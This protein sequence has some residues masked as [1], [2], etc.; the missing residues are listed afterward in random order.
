ML[1]LR[2]RSPRVHHQGRHLRSLTFGKAVYFLSYGLSDSLP[3][4]D[5]RVASVASLAQSPAGALYGSPE[6]QPRQGR[7]PGE[8]MKM[9]ANPG[10]GG[11]MRGINIHDVF[12]SARRAKIKNLR[13]KAP[14]YA[15]PPSGGVLICFY[16]EPGVSSRSRL[17]ARSTIC[18]PRQARVLIFGGPSARGTY[19]FRFS[20]CPSCKVRGAALRQIE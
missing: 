18:H 5:Y 14:L 12:V 15:T 7:N 4:E 6:V 19:N 17:H 20:R 3:I 10:R 11:I 9:Y 13:H 8:K 16:S 1:H 2:P